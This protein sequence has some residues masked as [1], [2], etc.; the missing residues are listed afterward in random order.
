MLLFSKF[1]NRHYTSK[2]TPKII[3]SENNEQIEI[4]KQE[5]ILS[6]LDFL[7]TIIL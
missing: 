1:R 3:L 2:I 4:V 5:D 6:E 7:R